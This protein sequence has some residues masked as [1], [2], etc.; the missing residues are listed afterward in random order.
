M[1]PRLAPLPIEVSGREDAARRSK[2]WLNTARWQRLRIKVLQRDQY[3][4]QQT[5]VLLIGKHPAPNSPVVDHIEPHR[6][7]PDLFWDEENL[8][9]VAKIWHDSV[10]QSMEKRGLA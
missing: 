8:Q 7:D 4:C 6:G 2:D 10:K 1:P 9:S 5:G 3:T